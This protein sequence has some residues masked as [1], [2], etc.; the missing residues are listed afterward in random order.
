MTEYAKVQKRIWNSKTF[1]NLSEDARLLWLYLL[2][3]PHGNMVGLFV[4]KPGYVQEDL[5]WSSQRFTKSFTELLTIP[6]SNGCHGLVKYDENTKVIWIKNYLEHNPLI[7]PNQV[8]AAVQ[9]IRALPYSE[10]FQDVKLFVQSLGKPL[11]ESLGSLLGKPVTVTVAVTVDNNNSKDQELLSVPNP[12]PGSTP[13]VVKI[14]LKDNSDFDVTEEM[15]QDFQEAYPAQDV[16][17]TLMDIRMWNISNKDRRKTRR[18]IMQHI[19]GWIQRNND[20]GKNRKGDDG[21]QLN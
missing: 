20:K 17:Q 19:T 2:T 11:Y 14:P 5:Q 3:C 16:R 9:K 12:K 1:S 6:L 7:N 4:L 18:G 21:W 15:F 10:L 8:K 13:P